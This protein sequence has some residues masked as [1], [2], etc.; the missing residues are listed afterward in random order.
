M[1]IKLFAFLSAAVLF[2][3]AAVPA[4]ASLERHTYLAL[5]DSVAFG[6][7]PLFVRAGLAG[8]PS[9]FVGYPEIAARTLGMKDVNASCPGETTGGFISIT[10]GQDYLC[11]PYRH[12]FPL[13]VNYTTSQLDFTIAYL[14]AHH[15]VRLIT[16]DIGANDVFKA[17]CTTTACIGAV[18]A[19]IEANLRFIYGQIRNVAHYHHALVTLTYYS[20]SY[21]AA[22]AAGTQSLNA[23][24][25]AATE[26]FGGKVASGFKA[27]QGPALAAGGSSCAAGLLIRLPDGTCDVHPTPLGRDLLAAAVVKAVSKS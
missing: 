4:S 14:K 13:H 25:I 21:D 16:M 2:V 11:L 7:N 19:G 20:L 5:G 3:L 18:L 8:N 10:N 27:F 26:A 23:P 15:D 24:I 12:N 1:R 6:Y 9:I 22:T 17:G